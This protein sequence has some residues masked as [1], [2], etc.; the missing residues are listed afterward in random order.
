[1]NNKHAE[2]NN[3]IAEIKNTL[4]GKIAEYLKQKRIS[5]LEDKMVKITSEDQNT[6]KRIKRTED[7]H[8]ERPL[9]QYQMHQHS[10]YRGP[11]R[12]RGKKKNMRKFLKR[13]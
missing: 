6:V 2:T 1:M 8:R 12:R 7:S 4:E 10:I 13:L 3:T 9:G 11:R 5:E